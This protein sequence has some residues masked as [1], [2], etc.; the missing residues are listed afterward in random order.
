[1][2]IHIY[3]YMA[4]VAVAVVTARAQPIRALGIRI[5]KNALHLGFP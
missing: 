4:E 2:Y 3:I 5:T 1:M